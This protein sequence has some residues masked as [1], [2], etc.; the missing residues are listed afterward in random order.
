MGKP[1][2]EWKR[3]NVLVTGAS[4]F[5]GASIAQ[6]LIE[7]GAVVTCLVKT[8]GWENDL[9]LAGATVYEGDIADYDLM[10]EILSS[11]EIEYVFHLAANAIVRIAARDPMS[12][13]RTNVMGTV[14][15][16]EAARTVGRCKK[17]I[18]ASSDKA[19]GDHEVLPYT[20]DMALQPKNTYDTSKACTDMIARSYAS[21]YGMPVVVTRCSNVYGPGDPNMS[22]IIPNSIC[23]VLRGEPP[24]LYED[25]SL[26]ER[27][28]IYIDDVVDACLRLALSDEKTNGEAYNIGGTGARSIEHIVGLTLEL[29]GSKM[30]TNIV[31][32]ESVFKEIQKQ[33]INAKKLTDAVG[34]QPETDLQTGLLKTIKYYKARVS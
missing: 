7:V 6:T 13:Y 8:K 25:V 5:I 31:K 34:W 11:Q 32:R 14:A 1:M 4:G 3:K 30:K 15:L 33:Y 2:S 22:R 19:Y 17:I 18:V 29:M 9:D 23:N 10:C 24:M 16:L 26:M 20:E 27:E 21:N 28:F 12:C